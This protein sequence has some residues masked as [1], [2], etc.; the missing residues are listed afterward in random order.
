MQLI[1]KVASRC[2]LNCSYCYVYNKGDTSWRSRPATMSDEVFAASIDRTADYCRAAGERSV[3]LTFHGG[4]PCLVGVERF[5]VWCR[6]ARERLSGLDVAI[7]IQ[8]NGTLID[9]HWLRAFH[10]HAV[11]VGVSIDGPAVIHD[12]FRVDHAG[13]GSYGRVTSALTMLRDAG[14]RYGLL[15]VIPLGSD[16]VVVHRH[17]VSLGAPSVTYLFPDYIHETIGEVRGLFGET[18]CADFL[19]GVFEEWW[20]N[21]TLEFQVRDLWNMARV[22]LGGESRIEMIGNPAPLYFFVE[23]DGSIEG[24]DA[25]RVCEDGIAGT[26]LNVLTASFEDVRLA[27]GLHSTTIFAGMPLP[28]PC[29]GC[30]E[31]L[32]CAGGY[33][34]HRY[35]RARA[36][37]N[38]SVWCADLKKLFEHIRLRLGVTTQETAVLR[39]ALDVKRRQVELSHND[40]ERADMIA[41]ESNVG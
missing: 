1:L 25:L 8:T 26:N 9:E 27:G 37:N 23:A 32:T 7:S 4:E 20:S 6:T 33:L 12:R 40:G 18:P 13:R 28:D 10:E 29:R 19:I 5:S 22:I 35:S 38:E 36:F 2:N 3:L 21:G 30:P 34:P 39:H 16:P 15:C 14:L 24:L 17:F 41:G 31:E 11:G